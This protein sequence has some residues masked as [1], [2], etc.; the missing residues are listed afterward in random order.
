[1]NGASVPQGQYIDFATGLVEAIRSQISLYFTQNSI[2]GSRSLTMSLVDWT[3]IHPTSIFVLLR[4]H[5]T[6]VST[7]KDSLYRVRSAI[8]QLDVY[9]KSF[10]R[11]M[12]NKPVKLNVSADVVAMRGS[13]KRSYVALLDL[14]RVARGK[15][16]DDTSTG[17]ACVTAG[18]EQV[19]KV[20][21]KL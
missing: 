19:L 6:L 18:I 14:L 15:I 12:R 10:K 2:S 21:V 16:R 20:L 1:M 17:H 8:G 13:V 11:D 9:D 3:A 5:R 7:L 4:I